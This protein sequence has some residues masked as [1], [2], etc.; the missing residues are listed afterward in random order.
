MENLYLTGAVERTLY[1]RREVTLESKFIK[2]INKNLLD[3]EGCKKQPANSYNMARQN[4]R[5]E[6]AEL[7]NPYKQLQYARE[8][9]KKR[10]EV[11]D[12]SEI[13][14]GVRVKHPKFGEGLVISIS[15]KENSKTATIIFD[16]VGMKQL[17]LDIAPLEII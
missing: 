17:A 5:D 2:E 8:S 9:E 11:R 3:E 6:R 4:K 7:F 1:G 14:D 15:E 16:S 12:S 10:S 13:K